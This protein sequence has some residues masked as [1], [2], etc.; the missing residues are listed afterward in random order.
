MQ[1]WFGQ[2]FK[3]TWKQVVFIAL[4]L[5][6]VFEF[7]LPKFSSRYTNDLW[8]ILAYFSGAFCFI[9][10]HRKIAKSNA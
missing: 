8:D 10:I 1:F 9:L 7:I 2:K 4:Y 3:L 5:S 6:V